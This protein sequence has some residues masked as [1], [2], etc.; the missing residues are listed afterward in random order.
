MVL[1]GNLEL[2]GAVGIDLSNYMTADEIEQALNA[3]ADASALSA[4]NTRVSTL[5]TNLN[6]IPATV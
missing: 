6:D 3:K 5:E 1:N 4:L 2:I